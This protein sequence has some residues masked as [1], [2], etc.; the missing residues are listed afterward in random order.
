MMATR[1]VFKTSY[2]I[3]KEEGKLEGLRQGILALLMA[4]SLTNL[5]IA[6]MLNVEETL[7]KTVRQEF[8]AS[9]QQA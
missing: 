7:V 8:M 4:T 3:V 5:E 1:K 2:E 6:K 9:K